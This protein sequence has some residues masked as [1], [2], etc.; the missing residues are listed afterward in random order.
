MLRQTHIIFGAALVT[1]VAAYSE[2]SAA[3]VVIAIFT[4]SVGAVFPDFDLNIRH[5]ALLH[6]VFALAAAF[7]AVIVTVSLL[8]ATAIENAAA[9]GFALS[10]VSHILLDAVTVRGVALLYPLSKRFY[11]IAKLRSGSPRA[12]RI[13]QAI[14]LLILLLSLLRWSSLM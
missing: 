5:R 12:N 9:L 8:G 14:S 3:E 7:A 4:S 6:S 1:A 11:R 13:L 2:W 10:Y